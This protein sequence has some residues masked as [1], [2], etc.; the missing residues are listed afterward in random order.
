MCVRVRGGVARSTARTSGVCSWCVC[1]L[2]VFM[3]LCE[4]VCVGALQGVRHA[5]AASVAGACAVCIYFKRAKQTC[6]FFANVC[7]CMCVFVCVCHAAVGKLNCQ[8]GVG[9]Y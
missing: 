1:G 7:V 5:R 2:C 4:C 8:N 3:C 6:M 9:R